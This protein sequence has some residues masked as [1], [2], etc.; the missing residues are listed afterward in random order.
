[1]PKSKGKRINV[2]KF[3]GKGQC[4]GGA[5]FLGFVGS[6]IYYIQHAVSFWDGVL[7]FLKAIV[8]PAFVVYKILGM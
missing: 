6:A 7:G 8:W 4:M 3:K 1:M 5:Y 2:Y